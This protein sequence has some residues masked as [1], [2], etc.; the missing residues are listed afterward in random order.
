METYYSDNEVGQWLQLPCEEEAIQQLLMNIGCI[1]AHGKY[2][3][4]YEILDVRDTTNL[5][6]ASIICGQYTQLQSLNNFAEIW[7][8]DDL[9]RDKLIEIAAADDIFNINQLVELAENLDEYICI[10]AFNEQE[11]GEILAEENGIFERCP[12]EL[13]DYIDYEAYGRDATINY[14]MRK[15]QNGYFYKLW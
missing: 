5:D 3:Y 15:T 9:D 4:D 10:E 7:Q 1:D 2:L 14:S 11:L 8:D 13:L 6:L 12:E